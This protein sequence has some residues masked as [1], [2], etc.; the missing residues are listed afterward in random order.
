MRKRIFFVLGLLMAV[1]VQTWA[2]D[3]VYTLTAVRNTSNT[4]YASTYDVTINGMTW[5]VP[6]NQNFD[7]YWRIGGKSIT[8]AS[9]VIYSKTAMSG[10]AKS[11]VIIHNGVSAT[12]VSVSSV[13]L[14]VASDAAFSNPIDEV[15]T[16]GVV[17]SS[18]TGIAGRL[19]FLPSSGVT[20]WPAGSYYKITFVI[21]NSPSTNG[22]LNFVSA[23][24]S[25][26][27]NGDIPPVDKEVYSISSSDGGGSGYASTFDVRCKGMTWN[28]PGNKINS[29]W[30]LGGNSI[31]SVERIITGKDPMNGTIRRIDI[32]HNGLSNNSVVLESVKLTVASDAEYT[33]VID[34]ITQTPDVSVGTMIVFTPSAGISEWSTGS[35]YKITFTITNTSSTNGGLDVQKIT[36][37]GTKA[38]WYDPAIEDSHMRMDTSTYEERKNKLVIGFPQQINDVLLRI[39]QGSGSKTPDYVSLYQNNTLT[40]ESSY[41]MKR[42]LIYSYS[43]MQMAASVGSLRYDSDIKATIWTGCAKAVTFTVQAKSTDGFGI[44]DIITSYTDTD[45]EGVYKPICHADT[46]SDA[47]YVSVD[48]YDKNDR[49]F[50]WQVIA[51]GGNAVTPKAPEVEGYTFAY[52]DKD[53]TNVQK[54]LKVRA[55]YTLNQQPDTLDYALPALNGFYDFLGNGKKGAVMPQFGKTRMSSSNYSTFHLA[56][57]ADYTTGFQ[58][59]QDITEKHTYNSAYN[60]YQPHI[61][62]I[63]DVNS[64]GIMDFSGWRTDGYNFNKFTSFTSQKGDYEEIEGVFY[65]P[66]CDINQDGRNDYL[67]AEKFQCGQ[68]SNGISSVFFYAYRWFV[69]YQQPDGSYIEEQMNLMTV[70]EYEGT[71]ETPTYDRNNRGAFSLESFWSGGTIGCDAPYLPIGSTLVPVYPTAVVDVDG[72]GIQDLVDE[73]NGAIWFQRENNKWIRI[74]SYARTYIR[75]L[76]NDNIADFIYVDNNSM[77]G[78]ISLPDSTYA[79]TLLTELKVDNQIYIYDYNRDGYADILATQSSSNNQT[80][81]AYALRF[82]NNGSGVF[83][84]LPEQNFGTYRLLFGGCQDIDGDGIHDLLAYELDTQNKTTGVVYALYG[85]SNGSFGTPVQLFTE[86]DVTDIKNRTVNVAD[87]DAD[88][89]QEIWLSLPNEGVQMGNTRTYVKSMTGGIANTS[90]SAPA[91]PQMN[92]SDGILQITWGNGS[93]AQTASADLTYAL[94]IG[95]TPGGNDLLAAHA[96]TDGTRLNFMKG[97][98]GYAHQYVMDLS[99]YAP[100]TIYASVQAIDAQ[101]AG[102]PWSEEAMVEHTIQHVNAGITLNKTDICFNETVTA[103]FVALPEG[104]IHEWIVEDGEATPINNSTIEISFN[105]AGNKTI[106][107]II[108]LDG[109]E[110][111]RAEA[112]VNVLPNGIGRQL[113]AGSDLQNGVIADYNFDGVYDIV[114]GGLLKT[115]DVKTLVPTGPNDPNAITVRLSAA[116]S[117]VYLY[118]WTGTGQTKP[119]GAWPGTKLTDIDA[120]GYYYY[121]FSPTLTSVNIIWNNGSGAQTVD[122][123]NVTSSTCYALNSTSGNDITVSTHECPETGSQEV[124]TEGIGQAN[125]QFSVAPNIWNANIGQGV[126][127]DHTHNGAIDYIYSYNNSYY[128][129]YHNG[130]DNISSRQ[131]DARLCYYLDQGYY[132]DEKISNTRVDIT[133]DGYYDFISKSKDDGSFRLV[134]RRRDGSY[135]ESPV[136]C[137]ATSWVIE[138]ALYGMGQYMQKIHLDFD[139]D[140]FTDFAYIESSESGNLKEKLTV[141]F[142]RGEGT[143]ELLDI[144]FTTPMPYKD[145]NM[146]VINDLNADGYWDIVGANNQGEPYILYNKNNTSFAE[147]LWLPLGHFEAFNTNTGRIVLEDLNNDG[148]LD[149][150]IPEPI[151]AKINEYGLY[152]WYMGANGVSQHGFLMSSYNDQTQ[153]GKYLRAIRQRDH[154]DLFNAG[155]NQVYQLVGATNEA[156]AAPTNI[157][158]QQTADGLLIEWDAAADDHTP[159]TLLRYNLSV[160]RAGKSGEEAYLISPQNGG[161]EQAA[162][163]PDYT[164]ISATRFFIPLH[165]LESREYEIALQ[166]IDLYNATSPFSAPVMAS[167]SRSPIDAPKLRCVGEQ[168]VIS[169]MAEPTGATPVWNFD[170]GSV[171]AGSGYGPYTV[172]WNSGGDKRVSITVDGV[173]YADTITISNP[174]DMQVH[175][176]TTLLME[177]AATAVVSD[178][179]ISYI[180]YAKIGA[181]AIYEVGPKGINLSTPA[182]VYYDKRLTAEGLQITAHEVSGKTLLT[183]ESVTIYLEVFNSNGC[184]ARFYT[185]VTVIGGVVAPTLDLVTVDANAHNM[186]HFT[187]DAT[188]FPQVRILKE[189]NVLNEFAE[190]AVVPASNGSYTDLTSD[191]TQQPDRYKIQGVMANGDYSTESA[192]HKTVH[193]TINRGVREGT[194]NLIWNAYEGAEI[195]TYN[196]LRGSSAATLTQI[197]SV[198]SSATSYTDQAPLDAEPYYVVEYVLA[199]SPS[200]SPVRR[201]PAASQATL[202]GRSNIVERESGQTPPEPVYYTIRFLNYDSSV[203]QSTRVLEGER[204]VYTGAT[205]AKPEDDNYTYEFSGWSP[206]ILPA[207]ADTDYTAQFTST[208]KSQGLDELQSDQVQCT[209]LLINGQIYILRGEKTY[210]LQGQET[211]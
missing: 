83:N 50:A 129:L 111:G 150:L 97:N 201:A 4:T 69:N 176:P 108:K 178:D 92:Y 194:Y 36:W 5:N 20:A 17:Q 155:N 187:A 45:C 209:K 139:H 203:L 106:T 99:T 75:D 32:K 191:A 174:E 22:G 7:G 153:Y 65:L 42:I 196:I 145:Y 11:L 76:N 142:N 55:I 9:R 136:N 44:S 6:G 117:N 164:Y 25:S 158:A 27:A 10:A 52:Y 137:T 107:H 104:Y 144:P 134:T 165:A 53:L 60:G 127:V 31:N 38:G 163:L 146:F 84:V 77:Y 133:H 157:R 207:F 81:Y 131:T 26:D 48:F 78:A 128:A 85:Q 18:Q 149:I 102:S 197:A 112:S 24:W 57:T 180:W 100:M 140:G 195:V 181:D 3:V 147:P 59:L 132:S 46:C 39:E 193:A 13:K 66:N 124:D 138:Q 115:G 161:N 135:T 156:P 120:N 205:P 110:L 96:M 122:I 82:I 19:I 183:E 200:A 41:F 15:T 40:I 87:L 88:G 119:C 171:V 43:D 29:Y 186:I 130:V 94:R 105:A 116:W 169:Y 91:K 63:G 159:A 152:A 210:T 143:F 206:A 126:W 62:H 162:V 103:T 35:Y 90:P 56:T 167:V 190:V 47:E 141:L 67:R 199:S 198:A 151:P 1:V 168:A 16:D 23:V 202:I 79:N 208:R 80:G 177:Q 109:V 72:D 71:T 204:P 172:T 192:I 12:S 123:T 2:E 113:A 37:Y 121:S 8:N 93:D 125:Y 21:T 34:E 114:A 95:T 118:A 70:D 173:T 74:N 184:S 68:M 64:D 185:P 30:R 14:T 188:N 182:R 73:N 154:L 101:Y 148:Y 28:V 49:K 211:R 179:V 58:P 170:G 86:A 89:K 54:N 175:L 33:T 166:T 98:M 51:R 61:Q 189:T 160:K